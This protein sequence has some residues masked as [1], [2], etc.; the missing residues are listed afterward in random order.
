MATCLECH[1]E[2]PRHALGCDVPA[3][4]QVREAVLAGEHPLS[5]LNI[6]PQ[7]APTGNGTPILPLLIADL[8]RRGEHGL[9]KYGT[10]LRAGNGRSALRDLYEELQDAALYVR[11]RLQEDEEVAARVRAEALEDAARAA[12]ADLESLPPQEFAPHGLRAEGE[13]FDGGS[14]AAAARRI[15]ARIRALKRGGR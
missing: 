4:E 9:Q 1:A 2:L 7:P 11:Q 13:R 6:H 14:S 15:A 3:V 10:V 5:L 8:H 12:E